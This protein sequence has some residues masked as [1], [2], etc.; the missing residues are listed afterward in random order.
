MYRAAAE[1]FEQAKEHAL[2]Q[3][4]SLLSLAHSSFC[5]ALEAGTEFEITRDM[6]TYSTAK[7]HMEAAASH[8]LRAGFKNASEY[9]RGTHRLF[10]TGG[11]V[12]PK[13]TSASPG[14]KRW[15]RDHPPVFSVSRFSANE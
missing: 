6:T 7:K 10:D 4:T 11:G 1:L 2:D 12:F 3:P 13:K 9:A 5:K 15:T 14:A 8:Y